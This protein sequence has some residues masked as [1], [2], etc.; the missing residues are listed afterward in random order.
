MQ[1]VQFGNWFN[2][3]CPMDR[4]NGEAIDPPLN[5]VVRGHR[6]IGYWSSSEPLGV[7]CQNG[8]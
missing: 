4:V 8:N 2:F 5:I 1:R 7:R 6:I 3:K